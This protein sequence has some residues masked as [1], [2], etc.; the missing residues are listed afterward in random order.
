MRARSVRLTIVILI[1]LVFALLLLGF[2]D[3]NIAIPGFPA[4][5]RGGTGPLGL[6]L[7]LDLR[8]GGH[9][10][11]QADTGT[12]LDITFPLPDPSRDPS[13][14]LIGTGEVTIE[15]TEH[16]H[17]GNADT[18][19]DHPETDTPATDTPV[20]DAAGTDAASGAGQT[21]DPAPADASDPS[22]DTGAAD[23]ATG[24]D[25]SGQETG[26]GEASQT[27]GTDAPNQE[28]QGPQVIL[29]VDVED[30]V[31]KLVDGDFTVLVRG[32]NSFSIKTQLLEEPAIQELRDG[33]EERFGPADT[34]EVS[35]VGEPSVDQMRGVLD[36]IN[37]RVN[38]SG[39]EEPIIQLFGDDRIVVQLPGA[40]GSLTEVRLAESFGDGQ[41]IQDVNEVLAALDLQNYTVVEGDAQSFQI[42]SDTLSAD[43]RE[44]LQTDLEARLG[45]IVEF[46]VSSAID[47]AKALIGQTARLEF[48]E[49]TCT[50]ITCFSYTDAD[51]GLSG[52]D[53]DRAGVSTD[54]LG[55][56]A[57]D[58]QF[59]GRGSEVF[60]GLTQR[61]FQRQDTGRIAMFLDGEELLAPVA[62]AWIRDGRSQITGNFSREEARTLAIQLESGRLPVPLK[63]IQ[64]SDVDALL[65]SES[66]RN[67]LM[68]GLVGLALVMVFMVAYYRASGVVASVALVFYT[69]VVLAIFKLAGITL[70]LSHIGGFILSIGMAVDANILIFERMKEEIRTG[71]TL[72]SS[73]EVGF[74]RAWPAIRDGNVS[75]FIT[76]FVL[77]WF[78]DRLGGGLVTGFAWGLL[79]G[80]AV[81]MFTAVVLSRNLLRLMAWAGLAHRIQLFTPEKVQR[82]A[83]ALSGGS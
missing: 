52:D 43:L 28:S 17:Q 4:L 1:I 24:T 77:L 46:E 55:E 3:I 19:H 45:L 40:S 25:A 13:R 71:R 72:A 83:S 80:V 22:T 59:D 38:R 35:E 53:L 33:L 11:Y 50:D 51:I 75:T 74:N 18:P 54:Q 66:L 10:V 78:G 79:I 12:R 26:A 69:I 6:K 81:S 20:S 34:F 47:E 39:T 44:Q 16:D 7:G 2:R 48:K 31:G 42:R 15:P 61:L 49:R 5:E 9:L 64:E 41:G 56:W 63:L 62:R 21:G 23:Q 76:C 37:R 29:D 14:T 8:G 36:I 73:M 70:T 32:L 68:A 58:I 60:S 67:S 30:A 27:T 82:S 65:G 57:I